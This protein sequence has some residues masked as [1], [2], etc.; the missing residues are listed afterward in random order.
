MKDLKV[1]LEKQ[2]EMLE[3]AQQKYLEEGNYQKVQDIAHTVI[4][5]AN[6]VNQPK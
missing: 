2:I 5:I 1:T 3:K 6:M 4:S